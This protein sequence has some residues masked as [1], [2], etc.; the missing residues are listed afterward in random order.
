M[1]G[2]LLAGLLLLA[3]ASLADAGAS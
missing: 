2:K 1:R 3:C